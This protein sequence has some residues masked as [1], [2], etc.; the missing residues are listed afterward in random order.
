MWAAVIATVGRRER[1]VFAGGVVLLLVGVG[2][3]SGTAGA[4]VAFLG[5]AAVVAAAVPLLFE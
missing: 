5:I 1:F 4:V 3:L 2:A